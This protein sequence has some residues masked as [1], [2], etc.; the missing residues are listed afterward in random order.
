M[1]TKND[2]SR[3]WVNG[4]LGIVRDFDGTSIRVELVADS[5]NTI[6][7]VLPVTWETY[8]YTYQPEQD[9]IVA[10]KIGEY[11]QYPLTLAWA[12]TIHKSQGKTLESVLVD[13]GHGTF[14]SGQVYVA[15]SRCRALGNLR[16]ARPL[17]TSDVK[18]DP[19]IKRFYRA[20]A[21]LAVEGGNARRE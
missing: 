21:E 12:V 6:C 2:E 7:D 9:R 18:C 16:L 19:I 20:L 3:R 10:Q 14:A 11:T 13:L 8:K 5:R 17:R 15:L 4:T 1:F